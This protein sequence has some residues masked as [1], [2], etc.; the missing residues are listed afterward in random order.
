MEQFRHIG[1]VLGSLKAFIV[2]Q[3][4]IQFNHCQCFLLLDIFCLAFDAIVE[5][6]RQNL[7]LEE[8][9]KIWKALEKPLRELYRIK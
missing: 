7:K 4:D 8:K 2:L 1:E 5:E 6:I 9:N 3:D